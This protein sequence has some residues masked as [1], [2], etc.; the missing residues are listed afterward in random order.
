MRAPAT[1]LFAL[2]LAA[3]LATARAQ[4]FTELGAVSLAPI[5]EPP[6][7][8][9]VDG[10][11]HA[12]DFVSVQYPANTKIGFVCYALAAPDDK[13]TVM[14]ATGSATVPSIA[15][16]IVIATD[17]DGAF[18]PPGG[19]FS[20]R[21]ALAGGP[22]TPTPLPLATTERVVVG[23]SGDICQWSTADSAGL[24]PWGRV[25]CYDRLDPTPT[26]EPRLDS[27]TLD[28]AL[29][30]SPWSDSNPTGLAPPKYPCGLS[31]CATVLEGWQLRDARFLPDG[32]LAVIA[33]R[34]TLVAHDRSYEK[35]D[36]DFVLAVDPDGA[37]AALVEPARPFRASGASSLGPS[38][39]WD[40]GLGG[41]VI[42]PVTRGEWSND[43]VPLGNDGVGNIISGPRG[44]G[45]AF[46]QI[47]PLDRPGI[48]TLSLT[49]A[50][51]ARAPAGTRPETVF[52]V[53]I[54]QG[55]AGLELATPYGRFTLVLDEGAL[56]LDED[57]LTRTEEAALGTSDW[58]ASSDEAITSDTRE[59]LA[60][61]DPKD[62]VDDPGLRLVEP[63]TLAPSPLWAMHARGDGDILRS[64]AAGAEAPLCRGGSCWD[65]AG[66]VV[67][68]YE[69]GAMALGAD[70]AHVALVEAGAGVVTVAIADGTRTALAT[71][72]ALADVG[73]APDLVVPV[74]GEGAF[75]VQLAGASG[76]RVAWLEAG[77][78]PRLVF[79]L[80]AAV[81]VDPDDLRDLPRG[82]LVVIGYAHAADARLVRARTTWREH[83][84]AIRAGGEVVPL[85]RM[86]GQE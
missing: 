30:I 38:L 78:A 33:R 61:T 24:A 49:D 56:D 9:G 6:E 25:E 7:R 58:T 54:E 32:R 15:T 82:E 86:T 18:V 4:T 31:N 14:Y 64:F 17:G 70:S 74:D 50:L 48:G 41:L 27:A 36:L 47:L 66:R 51:V 40:E 1:T 45:G 83:L 73:V 12:Y 65:A 68:T 72:A 16:T 10:T 63:T 22:E 44:A 5:V 42:G 34:T 62:P 52:G 19:W 71:P 11:G 37:V 77:Q 23:P 28:E 76:P 69:A 53:A 80:P 13:V 20:C 85:G 75:A 2:A 55:P 81:A 57:G 46:V 59:L 8:L 60:G 21:D 35:V 39:V 67:G 84:W 3:P 29:G 79:E 26:W 43:R